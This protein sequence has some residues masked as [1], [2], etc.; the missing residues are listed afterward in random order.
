MLSKTSVQ[1]GGEFEGL[2]HESFIA[3]LAV[4]FQYYSMA[5]RK[6]AKAAWKE[7]LVL[8]AR[9]TLDDVKRESG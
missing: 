4:C 3:F 5:G 9:C 2:N 1:D 6:C 7:A 8:Q